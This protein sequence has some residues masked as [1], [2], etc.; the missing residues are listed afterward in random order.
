MKFI[1]SLALLCALC[2]VAAPQSYLRLQISLATTNRTAAG[3]V[4]DYV[5]AR[6]SE[7]DWFD[8]ERKNIDFRIR[9]NEFGSAVYSMEACYIFSGT[10]R[11]NTVWGQVT[12]APVPA[13]VNGKASL[14]F[15]PTEGAIPDWG[16]CA[17]DPRAQYREFTW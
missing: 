13:S 9:T 17:S 8:D 1:L 12:N 14:H 11:A 3:N 2:E 4:R 16:S 5:R 6:V 15:C 10:N 7:V